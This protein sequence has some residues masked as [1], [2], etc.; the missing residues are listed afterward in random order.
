[1]QLKKMVMRTNIEH[2]SVS[3]ADQSNAAKSLLREIGPNP[4]P[5]D[6]GQGTLTRS[7]GRVPGH[8]PLTPNDDPS[9]R[10][11]KSKERVYRV[12]M[13]DHAEAMRSMVVNYRMGWGDTTEK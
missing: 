2:E 10:R 4:E 11:V 5:L 7:E 12:L 13:R 3:S 8:P 9:L 6:L 1:M